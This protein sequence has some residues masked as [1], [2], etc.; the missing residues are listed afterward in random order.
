[1][2]SPE[3]RMQDVDYRQTILLVDDRPENIASLEALLDDGR[4]E[5]LSATSGER[6]LQL[7]LEHDVAV[8]LLDVQMPGMNGYE[9]AR[10]MRSNR[11]TRHVPIIFIT[12]IERDEAAAIRGYQA[13]AIDYITKPVN[14]VVLQSKVTIFLELDLARR[15][16]QQAYLR[17]ENTKA[18]YES[19]LN[20]AGE[21]VIGIDRSGVVKFV[22]PAALAMLASVPGE[23][24]GQAFDQFSET[25][26]GPDQPDPSGSDQHGMSNAEPESVFLRLGRG[27]SPS[28][29]EAWFRRADGSRFL[30]SFCRSPLAGKIDGE[31]IVFQDITERRALEEELRQQTVTDFLT[32][33]GNRNAFKAAL[34]AALEHAR[35]TGGSHVALMF[36]DLDHFKRINDNLGHE[37]GDRLLKAVAHRLREQV[38]AYDVV[39]RLGGDEF[40]IVLGDLE[41]PDDAATVARKILNALRQPFTLDDGLDVAIGASI[42]IATWPECGED[43]EALMRTADVAMYQAKRDGRN[44]YA[45]Y[46]PEMNTRGQGVLLLEQALRLAVE[47]EAFCLHYQPQ[48][49]LKTGRMVGVEGL[50]RWSHAGQPIEPSVFVP[51]LEDTGLMVRAGQ[52]VFA[53]G[54]KQRMAWAQALPADCTISLNVSARQFADKFLVQAIHRILEQYQLPPSQLELELT[55]SI[56]M[57]NTDSTRSVLKALKGMGIRLSVDDFGTGYSSLAYLKQ[58]PLDALKI[59]KQFIR[60]LTTSDKDAAIAT[61]IIQLAH[62]LELEVVAEGVED[63]EQVDALQQ[64][65]CDIAQGYYFGRPMPADAVP[66]FP[67]RQPEAMLRPRPVP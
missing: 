26:H 29:E 41:F 12:A 28:V 57:S 24:V 10:L 30:S 47:N 62:N 9:V 63:A 40:T 14:S 60:H 53:A 37:V 36:I 66:T 17:L 43:T 59:D 4:R 7:L 55:E 6:A 31:V 52:W 58:F 44:L 3:K 46:Q 23:V 39:S 35:R 8:V 25:Q 11:K 45:F 38:R 22:N 15:R 21:G 13:G 64:L 56:L 20:A 50:M 2:N 42:G 27:V 67:V 61:S 54:C 32:G 16:L 34:H 33:L 18:Y 65:G 51:I 1:M 49:D 48:V 19:M 5:L